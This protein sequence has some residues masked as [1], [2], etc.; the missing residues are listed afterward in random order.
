M[1]RIPV[2]IVWALCLLAVAYAACPEGQSVFGNC[3]YKLYKSS[4]Q[5]S[6]DFSFSQAN[7]FCQAN[8]GQLVSIHSEAENKFVK[9]LIKHAQGKCQARRDFVYWIG[10]QLSHGPDGTLNGAT[11]T[12]DSSVD[13]GSPLGNGFQPPF[14]KGAPAGSDR[15]AVDEGVCPAGNE[16]N[17]VQI[18]GFGHDLGLWRDA[19]CS[20]VHKQANICSQTA[21]VGPKRNCTSPV[22]AKH[23]KYAK[24]EDGLAADHHHHDYNAT[25]DDNHHRASDYDAEYDHNADDH[26]DNDDHHSD[27]HDN[28]GA[29][30]DHDNHRPA[31]RRAALRMPRRSLSVP[32]LQ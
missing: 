7:A 15:N 20:K 10:L 8:G 19:N 9:G 26:H 23:D 29:H 17:C 11:W 14:V 1:G 25:V 2:H 4:S 13:F 22:K 31:A 27:D 12:D 5:C 21:T 32:A 3:C 16:K 6:T 24:N 28:R 30:Y 18:I